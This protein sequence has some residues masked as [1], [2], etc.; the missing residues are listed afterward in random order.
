MSV[1]FVETVTEQRKTGGVRKVDSRNLK[2]GILAKKKSRVSF[3]E[4]KVVFG[5]LQI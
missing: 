5:F 3:K 1:G 4:P 2:N